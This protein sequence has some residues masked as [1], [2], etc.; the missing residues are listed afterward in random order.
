MKTSFPSLDNMSAPPR[1]LPRSTKPGAGR[2][3]HRSEGVGFLAHQ[4]IRPSLV[5]LASTK[6]SLGLSHLPCITMPAL[7]GPGRA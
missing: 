3:H 4:L 5:A 2:R 6:V 7:T 1:P